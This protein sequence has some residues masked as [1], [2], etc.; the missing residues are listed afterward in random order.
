MKKKFELIGEPNGYGLRQIKYLRDLPGI[1]KGDLGGWMEKE[2]NLDQEGDARVSGNARVFGDARVYGDAWVSGD[3]RV[4]GNA[5]V[6]GDAW[7]SGDARVFGNARVSGNARVFGDAQ[8]FGNAQVFGDARVSGNADWMIVGPIG[9]RNSHTTITKSKD[10]DLV[11]CG[12][13]SG[14]IDEFLAQVEKTHGDN[15]HARAYKAMIE[16]WKA[17]QEWR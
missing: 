1:N 2:E 3:A 16:M 8:V 7:V 11:F 13:F 12:C 5:R 14:S 9:S 17:R 6:S 10:G 15:A 4:F